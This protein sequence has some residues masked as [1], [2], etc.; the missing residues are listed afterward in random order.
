[1]TENWADVQLGDLVEIK[2]GYAFKGEFFCDETTS[3]LLLTPGN[4]AIGGGFQWGKPKFYNG[5]IPDEYVLSD[6]D[7]VVTMTDLSKAADTLGYSAVIPKSEKTLLHNQR[8]GK[9]ISKTP[10]VDDGFL[11]YLLR[12]NNYRNEV[13][14]SATGSTV[15]HT[16]P[17]KICAY[18]FLLPPLS[19][20][21]SIASVLDALNDKIANNRRMN[22]TLEGM[23]RATFKSWF[24][25]FDPV[26]AK[27]EGKQPA[28]MDNE[29]ADLFPSSFDDNGL[30]TGW[31]YGEIYNFCAVKYGASFS[32][33]KFNEDG[34][35]RPL[36][37]IRDLPKQTTNVFS[38]EVHKKETTINRGDIVVGMDGE[39]R[40]YFWQGDPSLM[41]QRV[42]M[43]VPKGVVSKAFLKFSIEAPLS[44]FE[45]GKVGTTVIHLAKKDIDTFRFISPSDDLM[46]RFAKE[47][48]LLIDKMI[49]NTTEAHTLADLR[50]ML[51]PKFMSG[52]IGVRDVEREIEAVA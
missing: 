29:T 36:V 31:S 25:D 21:K 4:F 7:L 2:H 28:H 44:F 5:P 41:N 50:D 32:S 13:L 46:R 34:I 45:R 47:A 23:A 10:S 3:N 11:H 14:A 43:F 38:D 26:R 40:A 6:G 39:F 20:Q 12:T 19:E 42:C 18:R 30:P 22:E 51:L 27:G 35:G 9:V 8:I 33:K 37:R 52:E 1:V 24:V 49:A 17:T 48:D 16:S 15:K